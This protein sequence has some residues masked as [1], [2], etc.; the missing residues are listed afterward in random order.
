MSC[1]FLLQFHYMLGVTVIHFTSCHLFKILCSKSDIQILSC[2]FSCQTSVW[3]HRAARAWTSC[4]PYLFLIKY[5]LDLFSVLT[6]FYLFLHK[7]S[8]Q[9]YVCSTHCLYIKDGRFLALISCT[10]N[11]CSLS[12]PAEGDSCVSKQ[13]WSEGG[14]KDGRRRPC[15]AW[16][17]RNCHCVFYTVISTFTCNGV[18]LLWGICTFNWSQTAEQ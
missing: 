14:F 10:L 15:S 3:V 17:F 11:L 13:V 8:F 18:F 12:W 9:N 16:G 5:D 7:F 4:L 6:H 1:C 2:V